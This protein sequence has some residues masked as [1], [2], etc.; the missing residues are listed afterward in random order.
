MFVHNYEDAEERVTGISTDK[1]TL[2]AVIYGKKRLDKPVLIICPPDGE[3]RYWSQ[4]MLVTMARQYSTKGFT[5]IRFDYE[6]QGESFGKY[7]ETTISSRI[8]NIVSCIKYS[9]SLGTNGKVILVGIRLGATLA[10]EVMSRLE[11]KIL[12]MV[13]WE[14]VL[15]VNKYIDGLLRM[16]TTSQ[17]V[18]H[19]YVKYNRDALRNYITEGKNISI[20]G[21]KL[22][23]EFYCESLTIDPNS[24]LDMFKSK[25]LL[26]ING[27]FISNGLKD[28]NIK[29]IK[30]PVFWKEHKIYWENPSYITE[31]TVDWIENILN[32]SEAEDER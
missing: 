30:Y 32:G 9:D 28:E 13:L 14:P 8:D 17:M 26:L 7:E 31:N 4:R 18:M 11:D 1:S 19:G 29:S 25:C 27:E 22:S 16:H 6:G 2:H 23:K 12:A 5:V 20:N 3:E 24:K 10:L 21:Y 15:D